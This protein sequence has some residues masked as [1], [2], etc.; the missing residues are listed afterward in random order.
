M[1]H[2]SSE[3]DIYSLSV[4]PNAISLPKL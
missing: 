2:N 4:E 3:L 1:F